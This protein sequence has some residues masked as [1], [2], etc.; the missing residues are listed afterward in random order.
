MGDILR[1]AIAFAALAMAGTPAQ[2]ADIVQSTARALP[3]FEVAPAWPEV[4]AKWQLGDASSSA[5]VLCA[6]SRVVA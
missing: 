4:P 5:H 6:R 3:M 2:A 1:F